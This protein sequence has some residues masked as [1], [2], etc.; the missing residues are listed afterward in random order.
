MKYLVTQSEMK[1]YDKNTIECFN[2]PSIVLMERAALVTVEHLIKEIGD[3]KY[4]VLVVSGCGNNGGDGIA[5][6]RLLMLQGCMVDFTLL[7]NRENCSKETALQ[8]QILEGYGYE[9]YDRIPES[10]YDIVIDAVFGIGLSRDIEGIYKEAVLKIN[11]MDSYVCSIDIPS[12]IHAGT[13]RI[14]GCAVRANLTVTYGFIKLGEV[15]YP[16]TGC[17]G[18]IICGHMGIDEHSLMGS[19]PYWYT[20]DSIDDIRLPI[21]RPDGNKGTFGKALVIAGSDSM[22]GAAVMAGRSVFRM[23]AGMVK[24]VTSLKNRDVMLEALPEAMLTVYGDNSDFEEEFKKALSWADCILIGPGIG[25][26]GEAVWMLDMCLN[27]SSLPMVIDADGLN[28]LAGRKI[29]PVNREIILTPHLGE[30]ARLYGCSIKEVSDNLT[31]YPK[32]LSDKLN[33]IIV[34]K[35]ARTVVECPGA[36]CG[37]INTSGN[38]GMATAG[39]GDVLAGIITGLLAQGMEAKEA[40]VMGVCLH[41]FAGDMASVCC[42]ERSMTATDIIDNLRELIKKIDERKFAG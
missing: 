24:I 7:G 16:G 27:E 6:G 22:C 14:L 10:E 30:F 40:A 13:G 1:Q 28:I 33:C 20:Y 8:L 29:K 19:K 25:T 34:C 23:G 41:G 21:R 26:G 4:R 5:V 38:A 31:V 15:L 32:N 37:F 12:G 2:Y 3:A 11:E 9:L 35:D 39:S 42:G 18:K 17:C 36:D